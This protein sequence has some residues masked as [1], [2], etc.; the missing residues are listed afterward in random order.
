MHKL[1]TTIQAQVISDLQ[2]GHSIRFIADKH[3]IGKSTVQEIRAKYT[4]STPAL[5]PGPKPKLSPQDRRYCIHV[6]TSGSKKTGVEARNVLE[7]ELDKKVSKHTVYRALKEQGLE[8][9]KKV[10]KPALS[11]KNIC[12][13]LAFAKAHKDWTIAD[14]QRV[15]W[16]DETKINRFCSD[17]M[18]WCWKRDDSSLQDYHI[19]Q[20]VKFGGGSVMIWGCMT[21][22]GPGFMC[23]IEGAMDKKLYSQ[24]LK[25]ELQMTIDYYELEH[26]KVVFQQDNAPCHKAKDITNW[27]NSQQFDT[28]QWPAQSPDL[29][30]IETL[31]AILK[32]KLN[33]YENPPSG[34]LELWD[35]IQITWNEITTETCKKLVES[36][37]RRIQEVINVKGKWTSN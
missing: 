29:N 31:W 20:T 25:K 14:W 1:S 27:L 7:Q 17:G 37:P 33:A 19:S 26:E 21:H 11:P 23:R 18:S 34:I 6:V 9:V 16:S 32:Q 5:K 4:P 2:S 10:K 15:I 3:S 22:K 30:P 8:A 13:R 28:L 35:R 12:E 36:M 24:V